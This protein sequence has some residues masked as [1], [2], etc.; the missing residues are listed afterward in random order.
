MSL[1]GNKG[2]WSELYVLLKLL[3]TGKLYAAD[4]N[5][6]PLG[7]LYFPIKKIF[8][9][10]GSG[11]HTHNIEYHLRDEGQVD[12][13]VN[14]ILVNRVSH[15]QLTSDSETVLRQIVNGG[16]RSFYL[17]GSESIMNRLSC[18]RIKAPSSDKTD[19]TLLL[20]DIHTGFEPICGFSIKSDLGMPPTLLN[21]S[22]A[23]NFRYQVKNLPEGE[24]LNI[25]NI[26]TKNK[27]IDR[28]S[29]IYSLGGKLTFRYVVNEVFER[30]LTMIDSRMM[31]ILSCILLYYYKERISSC[32]DLANRL[33]DD[34]PLNMRTRGFYTY[35][36]KKFLCAV[37]LGLTP[38]SQWDGTEEANGG[39]IVIGENGSVLAY[40]IYNRDRFEKYLLNHT[41]LETASSSRHHYATIFQEDQNYYID[42]NLQIRFIGHG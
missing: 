21:A 34:N 40:H 2:E 33:E 31:E 28:I 12:V 18:D 16:D 36:L 41:K 4:E 22:C 17:V 29:S 6:Q 26:E 20:H 8:R 23:T 7:N 25:N 15:E 42:L 39:Y 32:A 14:T 37:A 1:T 9:K 5:T 10:E 24:Y 11:I 3:A 27:I 35:K 30:N 19:I 38:T 13:I